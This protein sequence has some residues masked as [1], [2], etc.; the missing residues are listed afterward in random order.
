MGSSLL[1]TARNLQLAILRKREYRY[2]AVLRFGGNAEAMVERSRV[3]L[4]F[5]MSIPGDCCI[6]NATDGLTSINS[7]FRWSG[8]TSRS[9]YLSSTKPRSQPTRNK[10]L[11]VST[12]H[13][14]SNQ[15]LYQTT[16]YHISDYPHPTSKSVKPH[17]R[18]SHPVID[19]RRNTQAH[20]HS[21]SAAWSILVSTL[22]YK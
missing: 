9:R 18:R 7:S 17:I 22:T 12:T 1:F 19:K 20:T 15:Y 21:S 2:R 10:T 5:E 14:E 11:T 4:F 3:S 8:I 6:R 16:N 13:R